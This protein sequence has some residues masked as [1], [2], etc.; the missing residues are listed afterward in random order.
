MSREKAFMSMLNASTRIQ[1]Y[2]AEIL[3]AKAV[4][5]EKSRNWICNHFIESSMEHHGD[6]LRQIN[7]INEHLLRVI[8]GITKMENALG[9]N[10]KVLLEPPHH[11]HDGF[12]G[13][14]GGNDMISFG[15]GI[16]NG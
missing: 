11:G 5:A 7:D 4:E 3:E 9:E 12:G 15:D 10:L 2:I 16:G 13:M 8:E 14:G 1:L 6:R